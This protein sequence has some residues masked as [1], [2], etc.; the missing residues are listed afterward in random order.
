MQLIFDW[1]PVTDIADQKWIAPPERA[2]WAV[3]SSGIGKPQGN[4]SD[5]LGKFDKDCNFNILSLCPLY[6]RASQVIRS[7]TEEGSEE[8][9][10]R[11]KL[12]AYLARVPEL[13]NHSFAKN[14]ND[15]REITPVSAQ[16]IREYLELVWKQYQKASKRARGL[17]LSELE[18]NLGVH[19]KSA[20]RL[21]GRKYPPRSLQGFKG[22]R[23]RRYSE[24]ARHHLERL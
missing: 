10:V 1:S 15:C 8:R 6:R 16:A 14:H 9:E 20:T 13:S 22:G 5:V 17:I 18:R 11:E 3:R 21:M 23:R 4:F 2:I 7:V 12:A 19:R 24:R